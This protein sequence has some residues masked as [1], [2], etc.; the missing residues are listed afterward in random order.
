MKIYTMRILG[1][2]MT[3]SQGDVQFCEVDQP[4]TATTWDGSEKVFR[5]TVDGSEIPFPT[6]WDGHKT[7]RK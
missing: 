1:V 7:R 4:T 2:E 5:T 6:T 3:K